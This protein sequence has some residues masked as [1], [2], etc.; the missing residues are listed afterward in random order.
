MTPNAP[1]L[2]FRH[3]LSRG[4]VLAL[5]LLSACAGGEVSTPAGPDDFADAG[6]QCLSNRDFFALEV[7]PAVFGATCI[8]C[9]QPGGIAVESD[10]AFHLLPDSYPGFIDAN[11]AAVQEISRNQYDGVSLLLAKPSA[12]TKHGGGAVIK[13]DDVPYKLLEELLERMEKGE[14]CEVAA[15]KDDFAGVVLLGPAE[16]YRKATLHLA[17]RLPTDAELK[18]LKSDGEKALSPLLSK[19]MQEEAFYVRLKEMFNDIFLSDRYYDNNDAVDLLND[20]EYPRAG[21]WYNMQDDATRSAINRSLDREP[22]EL[23]AYIVKNGKPFT[24]L[25]TANYTVVNPYTAQLYDLDVAFDDET[26]ETEWK[27]AKVRILHDGSRYTLPHAGILT[28]PI[29]LNR[30]PTSETNRNRHRARKVMSQ[31]LATDILRAAERPIDP[32]TATKYNNPTRDDPSCTGCH[33]QL[34]P[35][36]GAFMKWDDEDQE[37]FIPE[38]EW[39]RDMFA[40][41]FADQLI[42]VE[43]F[44]TAQRWLAKRIVADPRFALSAVRNMYTAL[45]GHAPLEYPDKKLA[46]Y[47]SL[48]DAWEVQERVFTGLTEKLVAA[49]FDLRVTVQDVV[50][51]P[52]FRASN[53]E[54]KATDALALT[55]VGTGRLLIPEVLDRK[56]AATVGFHWQRDW[57]RAPYLRGDYEIL[58]G[59]I[60]SENVISRLTDLNSVMTSVQWRMANEV[61]CS[62]AAFE[63]T[64]VPDERKLFKYVRLG[65]T[66]I[67]DDGTDDKESIAAIKKNLQY[68]HERFW[69]TRPALDDPELLASYGLFVETW[70]EGVQGVASETIPKWLPWAC[71]ARVNPINGKELPEALRFDQDP[72]YTV[73]SWMAV[74]T[75]LMTDYQFLYE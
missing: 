74:L 56:I 70:R 32:L 50:L 43:E 52:Y 73:R 40:P 8:E 6:S 55:D 16:T 9:H 25:L 49:N 18:R 29:W 30:F 11:Y 21:E 72:Q 48:L 10:A 12:L 59:G 65:T 58:Y 66:P 38:R 64:Q 36:A 19:L 67:A 69:G 63:F 37:E 3:V 35:I 62:A 39:Y 20:E 44:D 4:P 26:D 15:P 28:N 24:E 23:L 33:R 22:L 17:G 27:E 46:G 75:Y 57:D 14:P 68:L 2:P 1:P 45:T 7:W 54:D 71:Q 31:F 42:P 34:D 60:D 53:L 51:S 13:K 41:G 47:A 61:A 5:L